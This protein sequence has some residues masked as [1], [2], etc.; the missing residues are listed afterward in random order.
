M[1]PLVERHGNWSIAVSDVDPSAVFD[2]IESRREVAEA[3]SSASDQLEVS[4]CVEVLQFGGGLTPRALLGGTFVSGGSE[5]VIEVG[6]SGSMTLGASRECQSLL[7][8][9]LV[10][11]LP[12]EFVEPVLEGLAGIA[13]GVEQPAGTLRI[14][15]AGYDEENSSPHAF[16]HAGAAM[17]WLVNKQI[18]TSGEPVDGLAEIAAMW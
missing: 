9:P 8:G 12:L 10:R 5:F 16:R 14:H 15:A 4:V 17:L 18:L 7:G 13:R 6:S 11:G 2:A 3:E 1:K